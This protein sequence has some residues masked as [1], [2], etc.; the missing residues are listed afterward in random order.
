MSRTYIKSHPWITFS[1]DLTCRT[2]T[3]W[4]L[5]GE[6]K[7]KCEHLANVILAPDAA[8]QLHE[9]YLAKGVLATT[10]IE[11]NTLTEEEV[12]KQIE[13]KLRLP[14]SREYLGQETENIIS[15][16]NFILQDIKGG[17][18]PALNIE[19][20]KNFNHRVLDKLKLDEGII[21]GEIRK[22]SVGV[23]RYRA[24]PS[25]DCEYLLERLCAWLS[26]STFSVPDGKP[27]LD[28]VFA[29]I[30]AILAHLYLAWI[31]PFG[32][33]NGRTARLV[34]LLILVSS[35]VPSSAAH[36]L[37][38]HYNQTRSEY[39]RQLDTS[40]KSGG[41]VIPFLTYALQGF[42]DGLRSQID[43]IHKQQW[44]IAWE[45]YVHEQLEGHSSVVN[46]RRYNLVIAISSYDQ[47]VPVQKLLEERPRVA[48]AYATRTSK[49]LTRDLNALV[50]KGLVEQ[51][52][53]KYRAK[54]EVML[55]FRPVVAKP[56]RPR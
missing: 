39:Y 33:G 24:A 45:N 2:Q 4:M 42:V 35:G 37:S 14:P 21:P 28:L 13:G 19:T 5:L 29:I 16:C 51:V 20:V 26:G 23:G 49:T 36:L 9:I 22:G 27:Q 34:E 43:F 31:H 53:N 46:A 3:L 10:A 32:D 6:A 41:D 7:S 54:K 48:N 11:G 55:A 8:K 50:D 30:K 15:A 52:A 47:L 38:N 17:N 40:S 44:Q 1:L 12:L 25:E 56:N 18:P